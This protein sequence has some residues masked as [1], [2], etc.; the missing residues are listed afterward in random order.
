MRLGHGGAGARSKD[1]F[2]ALYES[3]YDDILRYAR[4]RTDEETA[5]DVTAETFAVAWRR[6]D[7]VPSVSLPWLYGVARRV[8]A[9][10]S[11]RATRQDR[12]AMR[13]ATLPPS[14]TDAADDAAETQILTAALAEL[15]ATDREAVLLVA[16]EGL[17]A[18]EA[19]LAAGCSRGAFAVR[20]HRARRR[21]EKSMDLRGSDRPATRERARALI[22]ST[23]E[24]E[25]E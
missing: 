7:V 2:V 25:T 23:H 1:W 12:V 6:R 20:L 5:R 9:N 10:E 18:G 24:K 13:I 4:R 16:W 21:L 15:S 14:S 22:G 3:F 11:R 17:D 8:L 19:A